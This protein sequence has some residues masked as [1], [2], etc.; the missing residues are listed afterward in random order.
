MEC[1]E[2]RKPLFIKGFDSVAYILWYQY[3]TKFDSDDEMNLNAVEFSIDF[4][5]LKMFI[6]G[7]RSKNYIEPRE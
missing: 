1:D 3:T 6:K 7:E 5:T 2:T 4:N